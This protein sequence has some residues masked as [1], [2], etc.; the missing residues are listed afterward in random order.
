VRVP[1]LVGAATLR[2]ELESTTGK[3][4]TPADLP[5]TLK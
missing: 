1:R 5:V 3:K 2:I 4:S